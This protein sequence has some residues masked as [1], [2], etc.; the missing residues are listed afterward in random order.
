MNPKGA[1]INNLAFVHLSCKKYG[2]GWMD[3]WVENG[4]MDGEAG[5]RI[6]YSNQKRLFTSSF[7]T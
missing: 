7:R 4:W 6:G 2:P 1:N 3:G 5:L